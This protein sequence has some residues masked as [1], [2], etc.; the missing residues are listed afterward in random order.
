[1]GT[2]SLFLCG[3]AAPLCVLRILYTATHYP[4]NDIP[5]HLVRRR[6]CGVHQLIQLHRNHHIVYGNRF[7][8]Q[9]RC[10]SMCQK[11]RWLEAWNWRQKKICHSKLSH[12]SILTATPLTFSKHGVTDSVIAYRSFQN[13]QSNNEII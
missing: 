5:S 1:M 10:L 8:H 3:G 9:V 2:E 7:G 6:E 12:L 11:R 13:Q 4:L